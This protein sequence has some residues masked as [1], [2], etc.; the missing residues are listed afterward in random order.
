MCFSKAAAPVGPSAAELKAA[1][2]QRKAAEIAKDQ[3]IQEKATQKREDIDDALSA[4]TKRKGS[5]GG[6]GRR[7]LFSSN[8]G[9]G[10]IGRFSR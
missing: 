9:S 2:D 4:R 10:F 8:T 3:A 5:R 7:S 1:E 6:V